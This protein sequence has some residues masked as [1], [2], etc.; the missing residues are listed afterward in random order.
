LKS[1]GRT[2]GYIEVS[3]AA[4]TNGASCNFDLSSGAASGA[5]T[6]GAGF[7][8]NASG[9]TS[10]GSGWYR[11]FLSVTSDTD[12]TL[13]VI[14]AP[15]SA[16]AIGYL[17][18]GSDGILLYGSQVEVGSAPTDY[19]PVPM[20][21]DALPFPLDS[22]VWTG[23]PQPL[24]SAFNSSHNVG[25]FNG[26][27]LAATVET[28]EQELFAGKKAFL[29]WVRPMVDGSSVSPAVSIGYRNALNASVSYGSAVT[30][31]TAGYCK[32]RQKGR[33]LRGRITT[34][35]GETWDH[36]LGLDDVRAVPEGR[37]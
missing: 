6:Y 3:N 28:N 4:G 16:G 32:F 33:Y 25:Y 21:L 11:A 22:A 9:T 30:V 19:A 14:I 31:D 18:N 1:A 20:T 37:R 36:I 8:I 5:G 29:R 17:G 23:V 2:Q 27:N 24:F 13:S 10:L 34:T 15:L 35:A 7:T 26:S 12:T